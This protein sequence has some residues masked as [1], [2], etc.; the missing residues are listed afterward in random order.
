MKRLERVGRGMAEVVLLV[1]GILLAFWIDASWE[2]HQ[3]RQV[4]A[5]LMEA[6][7]QEVT[8]NQEYLDSFL[9]IVDRGRAAHD[10]FM[11]ASPEELMKMHDDSVGP[12]L[13]A[14]SAP[15][16][17]DPSLAA[18]STLLETSPLGSVSGLEIRMLL[19]RW[20]RGIEDSRE[21]GAIVNELGHETIRRVVEQVV[22]DNKGYLPAGDSL[23][24]A[25][26][27]S[28]LAQLRADEGFVAAHLGF[29]T[30]QSVYASEIRSAGQV[31]DSLALIFDKR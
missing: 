12:Q 13:L 19:G 30:F 28:G 27:P 15:F 21:E 6:V 24:D 4:E 20:V 31:L 29:W 14:L 5:S 3:L 16:T 11:R 8:E 7:D 17:Y 2:R 25:V 9:A 10:R 26:G 18:T 1:V 23:F 22:A